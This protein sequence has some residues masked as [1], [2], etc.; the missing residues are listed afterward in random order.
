M[1]VTG[2]LLH[3]LAVVGQPDG[4]T[5]QLG[6]VLNGGVLYLRNTHTWETKLNIQNAWTLTPAL[7]QT[8]IKSADRIDLSTQYSYGIPLDFLAWLAPYARAQ[9]VSSVL[10]G[11]LV[12]GN[13]TTVQKTLRDGSVVV[14]EQLGTPG[15]PA[16]FQL[17]SFFEPLV[18]NENVGVTANSPFADFTYFVPKARLGVGGQHV[19]VRDGFAIADDACTEGIIELQ[20]MAIENSLGVNADI[21]VGGKLLNNVSYGVIARFYYPLY[22]F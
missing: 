13:P 11:Q 9:A 4:L 3:S 20:Q 8:P 22:I 19:I 5:M 7:P 1:G 14:E 2:S 17:S 6:G 18:I 21:E 12:S 15:K 10:P 16:S